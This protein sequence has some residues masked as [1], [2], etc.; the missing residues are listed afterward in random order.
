LIFLHKK[1]VF[2]TEKSTTSASA[3]C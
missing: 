3:S 1:A 2:V